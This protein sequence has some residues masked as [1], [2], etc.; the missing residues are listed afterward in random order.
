MNYFNQKEF[1]QFALDHVLSHGLVDFPE[2]ATE[3]SSGRWCNC[4]ISWREVMSDVALMDILT[5]YVIAFTLDAGLKP[6]CFHAVSGGTT[7]LGNITQYKWAKMQQDFGVGVYPISMGR[8]KSKERGPVEER[9]F[10]GIPRGDTI[11]LEDVDTTVD[12]VLREIEKVQRVQ[13]NVVR[14]IGVIVLTDRLEL[15]DDGRTAREAI[16][17]L[18]IFYGV[19]SNAF[20]LIIPAYEILKPKDEIARKVKAYYD[21]Y[22]IKPLKLLPR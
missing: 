22:G 14:I 6:L 9:E 15:R 21:R 1:I 19:L 12:S 16:E 11:I 20:Q 3:F 18:G 7:K 13:E 10:S 2:E 17:N 5:D 8:E 4:K